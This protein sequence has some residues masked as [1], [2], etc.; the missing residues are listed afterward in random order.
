MSQKRNRLPANTIGLQFGGPF[1]P[2]IY[3]VGNEK[4]NEKKGPVNPKKHDCIGFTPGF[5]PLGGLRWR[6]VSMEGV[7]SL[8]TC[9]QLCLLFT[10]LCL[11]CILPCLL[12]TLLCLL[13][14]LLCL[15]CTLLCLLWDML[16]LLCNLLCLLGNQ[17]SSQRKP[18]GSQ[19]K[20]EGYPPIQ[21]NPYGCPRF[22]AYLHQ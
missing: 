9:T 20:E 17:A 11:L 7:P 13:W 4:S 1:E 2:N 19:P 18:S 12:H 8:P 6:A 5:K 22:G 16:C 10:V 3:D 15:L 21:M 14:T